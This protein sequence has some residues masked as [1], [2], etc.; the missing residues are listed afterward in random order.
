[1]AL[2]RDAYQFDE[3]LFQAANSTVVGYSPSNGGALWSYS[4][5]ETVRPVM[6]WGGKK[7][8]ITL[9]E[10]DKLVPQMFQIC[11]EL[12]SKNEAP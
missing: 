2:K 11:T 12:A 4:L 5:P 9:T 7:S 6:L 1:M 8:V 3:I 10:D